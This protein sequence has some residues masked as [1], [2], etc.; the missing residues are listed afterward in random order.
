MSYYDSLKV[1]RRNG[2]SHYLYEGT[3]GAGLPVIQTLRDLRETGDEIDSIEGIFSGTLA[4]L[5]N[6][7]DGSVP[8]SAIVKDAKKLGYTEPDPRDDLSGLDVARKLIILAREMGQ[9][10]EMS[11][12]KVASLV[13]VDLAK[14]TIDEFLDGLSAHD[15]GMQKRYEAAKAQGKVLRYVGRITA[16]GEATVGL[17]ELD[18]KHAFAEHRA[19]RQRGALRDPAL[20]QERADRAGP[21]RRPRSDGRRRVRRSAAS[22]GLPG[23]TPVTRRTATAFAPASVANVAI[24]FDI[25]GFSVDSLGDRVTLTRS[26]TPASA[27]S[28]SAA[29]PKTCRSKRRR[30]RPVAR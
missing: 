7:Y 3:V 11:D 24:G 18:R 8:F 13:P 15:A 22:L 1:A 10:L 16:K 9:K 12:V 25:L 4:Y 6:V 30:T 19:H 20:Q 27:C 21:G 2:G 26:D 17:V 28:R 23:S 29:W 14:G 5:F